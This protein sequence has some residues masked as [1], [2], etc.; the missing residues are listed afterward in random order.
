MMPAELVELRLVPGVD[1]TTRS[2]V[3]SVLV[4]G[5]RR[6]SAADLER[7][8]LSAMAA[9]RAFL[10]AEHQ[11]QLHRGACVGLRYAGSIIPQRKRR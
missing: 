3:L 8:L 1:E 6:R 7:S 2:L 5:R 9:V 4:T 11:Q 10:V